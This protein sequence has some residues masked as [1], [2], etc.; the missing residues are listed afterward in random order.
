MFFIFFHNWVCTRV[1]TSYTFVD[2][3]NSFFKIK[4]HK[5]ILLFKKEKKKQNHEKVPNGLLIF[6]FH[7]K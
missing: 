2:K 1:F 6:F 4:K 3:I 7:E 5:I